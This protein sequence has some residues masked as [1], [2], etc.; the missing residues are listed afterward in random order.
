MRAFALILFGWLI[1][2]SSFAA[3]W[4]GEALPRSVQIEGKKLVLNGIGSRRATIMSV[5]VYLAGL[6]V[7]NPSKDP[8]KI[9][10]SR[11]LKAVEMKFVR[12]VSRDK[13]IE[14]WDDSYKKN[15]GNACAQ[16]STPFNQLKS[17]MQ[18]MK[19]G[20]TMSYVFREHGIEI[21]IKDR[22]AI[23]IPGAEFSKTVLATWLGPDPVD[24]TLRES[25]VA[26]ADRQASS[27]QA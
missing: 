18:N 26:L 8:Q 2:S 15:C 13:I 24:D 25:L 4:Q 23:R 3:A 21:Q 14:A 1:C 22:P 9:L 7:E 5:R 11:Q 20:D 12:D 19:E 17:L 6:Y 16:L 27:G 10:E